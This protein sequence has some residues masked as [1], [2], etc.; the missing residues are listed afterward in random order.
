MDGVIDLI[1]EN[2]ILDK[3]VY[4]HEVVWDQELIKDEYTDFY[5]KGSGFYVEEKIENVKP[6]RR[7]AYIIKARLIVYLQ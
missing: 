6:E 4:K 5:Y 1:Q 3:K 2:S 7:F